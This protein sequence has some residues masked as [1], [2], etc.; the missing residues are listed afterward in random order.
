MTIASALLDSIAARV[1]ATVPATPIGGVARFAQ[2][3]GAGA[4][5]GVTSLRSLDSPTRRFVVELVGD[6]VPRLDLVRG[7]GQVPPVRQVYAVVVAYRQGSDGF[8]LV[9][10]VAEDVEALA[11]EL[12]IQTAD[13]YSE[14]TTGLW[15]RVV[16]GYSVEW[17]PGAGGT[18]LVRLPVVCDY[19]P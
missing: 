1:T 12:T 18:A 5:D 3:T 14:S 17:D 4:W 11:L 16:E 9:R 6:R 19:L 10:V 7:L 15:R 8:G 13:R 2:L